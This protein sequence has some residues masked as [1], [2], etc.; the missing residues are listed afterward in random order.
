MIKSRD[1]L[2]RNILSRTHIKTVK[3]EQEFY[4]AL[5]LENERILGISD[6]KPKTFMGRKIVIDDTI[7]GGY[8]VE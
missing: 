7:T 1:S 4:E 8:D 6:T 3:M 5:R 2:E